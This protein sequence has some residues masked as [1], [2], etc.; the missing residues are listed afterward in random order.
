M[1]ILVFFSNIKPSHVDLSESFDYFPD[2]VIAASFGLNPQ[3]FAR[4]PKRGD[5]FIAAK[6]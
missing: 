2:D 5:V 4:L 6:K 1:D 3:A